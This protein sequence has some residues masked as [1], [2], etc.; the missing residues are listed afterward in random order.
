[1]FPAFRQ[2]PTTRAKASL[3]RFMPEAEIKATAPV[4]NLG[5][6]AGW[7]VKLQRIRITNVLNRQWLKQGL[8]RRS[9]SHGSKS[10]YHQ[11]KNPPH[12]L[13]T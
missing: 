4:H 5:K 2:T 1:M 8:S 3:Y 6:R 10:Q 9:A 12:I 7:T 13:K 11:Y